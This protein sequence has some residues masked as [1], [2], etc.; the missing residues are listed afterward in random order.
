MIRKTARQLQIQ[1]NELMA[2]V[3]KDEPVQALLPRLATIIALSQAG[4]AIGTSSAT[5]DPF[6]FVKPHRMEDG[7]ASERKKGSG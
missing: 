3:D 2:A 7:H 1:V 6:G 4:L 5:F